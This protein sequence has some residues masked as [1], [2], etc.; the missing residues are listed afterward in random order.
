M[1]AV[2]V[3]PEWFNE[4]CLT[5]RECCAPLT[6]N[7]RNTVSLEGTLGDLFPLSMYH[8]PVL[9]CTTMLWKLF[10]LA[11]LGRSVY[12]SNDASN[13]FIEPAAPGTAGDFTQNNVYVVGS[14][15]SMR[16]AT[17]FS[18]MSL[19]IYQNNNAT[20]EYLPNMKFV[21]TTTFYKWT[22]D[23][24]GFDIKEGNVFFFDIFAEDSSGRQL[25]SHYFN[26]SENVSSPS[27]SSLSS[28][29][30]ASLSSAGTT[31]M[32]T[33]VPAN[34]TA[35]TTTMATAVPANSTAGTTGTTATASAQ[36]VTNSSGI[37]TGAKVGIGVGVSVGVIGIAVGLISFFLILRIRHGGTREGVPLQ[38]Y[39]YPTAPHNEN[40]GYG[41]GQY[42]SSQ[43]PSPVT[44]SRD[45]QEMSA[46]PEVQELPGAGLNSPHI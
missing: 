37:S 3:T 41:D 6:N 14:E 18:E 44:R 19:A 17:N 22:V 4:L 28:S 9:T 31:T 42:K 38:E 27:S 10:V 13:Y 30:T 15:I 5:E 7:S 11:L 33:V 12:A 20:F 39:Q 36:P 29:P 1:E 46:L 25:S 21:T 16:W 45:P 2:T 8:R 35:G 34:S 32:A 40:G 26:I 23:L 43:D 24:M